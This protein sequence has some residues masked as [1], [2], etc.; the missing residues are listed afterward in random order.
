PIGIVDRKEEIFEIGE[1][2]KLKDIFVLSDEVYSELTYDGREHVSIATVPG[3]KDK[4]IVINGLSKSHA[5]TGWRIGFTFAPTYLTEQMLK[6]HQYNVS[7]ASSISQY[8]AVEALTT[9]KDNPQ[10]MRNSYQDRRD[11]MYQ[12][13]KEMGLDVV[14]PTGAFYMFPSIQQFGLS[15]L[16]FAEQ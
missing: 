1:L 3:M 7:C 11:F 5:M 8:A 9:M 2:L 13:L 14:N 4:T 10:V 16:A 15:S 6:V 12:R